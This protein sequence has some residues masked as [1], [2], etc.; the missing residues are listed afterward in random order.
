MVSLI[1]ALASNFF[2]YISYIRGFVY[3]GKKTGPV[4][5]CFF[6]FSSVGG[7]EKVHLDILKAISDKNPR[8]FIRY[9]INPWLPP[10]EKEISLKED[11]A[12]LHLFKKYGHVTFLSDYLEASS[13][14]YMRTSW[15]K[16]WIL[17]S[18]NVKKKSVLFFWNDPFVKTLLPKLKD[19]V[20][21]I[22]IVH[23]H[24]PDDPKDT[25]Y[26]NL[27][28]VG[29]LDRR[30]LV[31]PHLK[32]LLKDI[33]IKNDIDISYIDR[34]YV[35]LNSVL[36][37]DL[38]KQGQS[39]DVLKV[40][41]VARDAPEKRIFLVNEIA[42]RLSAEGV[43]AQFTLAGPDPD[44]WKNENLPNVTYLGLLMEENEIF[45]LYQNHDVFL[46][47][48]STEG[49]PKTMIEAM[50]LACIP[51]VS[52]AGAIPQYINDGY[53]GFLLPLNSEEDLIKT[54]VEVLKKL[55]SDRTL[56]QKLSENTYHT[57]K[58]Y[59]DINICEHLYRR[60]IVPGSA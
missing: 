8:V 38:E 59:F 35:I 16:G 42:R 29:R 15:I 39:Y 31:S 52:S 11:T 10:K 20:K 7:A 41:F 47:T 22:D 18:L 58:K 56:V 2:Y 53:N 37:R 57:A 23:N 32:D 34:S 4:I 9:K 51:V 43:P 19:R 40:I 25:E 45:E 54:A 6:P 26:L 55:C 46:L 48:S 21:V 44:R 14:S 33:Y 60:I 28:V 49:M 27:D 17:G 12:W 36:F 24:R 50:A 3:F 5:F 1:R 13:L 30:I